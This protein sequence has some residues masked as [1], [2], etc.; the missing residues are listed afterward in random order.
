MTIDPIIL[1][2]LAAAAAE[3]RELLRAAGVYTGTVTNRG[4]PLLSIQGR[5]PS[6]APSPAGVSYD[7]ENARW[8]EE[9][10]KTPQGAIKAVWHRS[11]DEIRCPHLR[12]GLRC[13]ADRGH[14]G[15][16]RSTRPV[17]ETWSA[18]GEPTP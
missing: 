16:C 18:E 15:P 12:E 13:Q 17:E 11:L 10:I 4:T 14:E 5:V 1:N 3:L 7:T 2:R 8:W 6:D 9:S